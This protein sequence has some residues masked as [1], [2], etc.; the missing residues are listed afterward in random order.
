MYHG[1]LSK[2][3][4]RQSGIYRV[5]TSENNNILYVSYLGHT[6]QSHYI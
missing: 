4:R 2:F 1:M 5:C 6:E 3:K